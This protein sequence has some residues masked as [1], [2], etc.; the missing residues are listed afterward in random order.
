MSSP[1]AVNHGP[2][3]CSTPLAVAISP[4][5]IRAC[6]ELYFILCFITSAISDCEFTLS[7]LCS[8]VR[9]QKKPSWRGQSSCAL[10]INQ[11]SSGVTVAGLRIVSD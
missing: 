10:L 1:F 5:V 6:I 7:C 4:F 2:R 11:W 8:S 3:S 9:L